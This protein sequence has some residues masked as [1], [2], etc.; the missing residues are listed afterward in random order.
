MA[1]AEQPLARILHLKSRAW[2]SG[3]MAL[4]ALFG[5]SDFGFADLFFGD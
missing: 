3:A 5:R 1:G 2:P 4:C